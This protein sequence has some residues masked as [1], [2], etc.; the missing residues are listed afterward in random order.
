MVGDD[1]CILILA[2]AL[3]DWRIS[4]FTWL[5]ILSTSYVRVAVT[6]SQVNVN[7]LLSLVFL[8][9]L[10]CNSLSLFLFFS[11]G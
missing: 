3:V 7:L 6:R 11:F 2:W 9:F 4:S 5:K 1:C 8:F 10:L